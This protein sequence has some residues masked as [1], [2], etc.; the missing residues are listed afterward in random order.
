MAG[1]ILPG[2]LLALGVWVWHQERDPLLYLIPP[3]LAFPPL[4][5]YGG[6]RLG[7][8]TGWLSTKVAI[9]LC[10]T[11]W[12]AFRLAKSDFRWNRLVGSWFIVPWILLVLLSVVW[13]VLGPF[14][15]DVAAISNESTRWALPVT[16]GWC[17]AGSIHSDADVESAT[18]V[19]V[20]TAL[21][22]AAYSALQGLTLLGYESFV[23]SPVATITPAR[24]WRT[25]LQ[26]CRR[27]NWPATAGLER[28][29]TNNFRDHSGHELAGPPTRVC[30]SADRSGLV[31]SQWPGSGRRTSRTR[32]C[33]LRFGEHSGWP[34]LHADPRGRTLGPRR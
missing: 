5:A 23:P 7:W 26:S 8:P 13:V 20:W 12:A 19:V 29:G 34:K 30:V 10:L 33:S 25:R 18:R 15:W 6:R 14:G 17:L 3:A 1:L 32:R 21:A 24:S 16:A 11:L 2:V 9:A 27:H 4:L 28:R 22:V 31:A